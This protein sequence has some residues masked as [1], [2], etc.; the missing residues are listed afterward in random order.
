MNSEYS[1]LPKLHVTCCWNRYPK[2]NHISSHHT[3]FPPET[4]K[5]NAKR[6]KHNLRK[7]Q[8]QFMNQN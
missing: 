7:Q 8:K 6:M 3:V 1:H 2:E 4:N 5:L